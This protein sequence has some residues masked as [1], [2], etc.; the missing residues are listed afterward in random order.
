MLSRWAFKQC[1]RQA[2]AMP[3]SMVIVQ[4]QV[5][6]PASEARQGSPVTEV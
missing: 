3:D 6:M 5:C 2:L 1:C 4:A